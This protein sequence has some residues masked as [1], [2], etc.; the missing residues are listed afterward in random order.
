MSKSTMS[1]DQQ[2]GVDVVVAAESDQHCLATPTAND[3]DDDDYLYYSEETEKIMSIATKART[4]AETRRHCQ[5]S[6]LDERRARHQTQQQLADAVLHGAD[7]VNEMKQRERDRQTQL[8]KD[9]L[10]RTRQQTRR[11][12]DRATSSH[13][14]RQRQRQHHG[15]N[16]DR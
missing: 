9:R 13:S 1:S 11:S 12:Y 4:K 3:D 16:D 2:T 6:T 14:E 7:K 5:V 8:V 10:E 15:G